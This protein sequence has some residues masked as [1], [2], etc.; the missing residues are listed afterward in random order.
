[1]KKESDNRVWISKLDGSKQCEAASKLTPKIAAEQLKGAGVV[2][3][4]ARAGN[5]GKMHI[6]KCGAP[7]GKTV[8]LEISEMDLGKVKS[9]GFTVKL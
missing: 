3:F 8:E 4:N 7:T 1:V 6:S 5:D 2:V 9:H